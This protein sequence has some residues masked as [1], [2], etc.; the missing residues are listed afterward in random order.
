MYSLGPFG[1]VLD[2]LVDNPV[3]LYPI[4]SSL[5]YFL[6]AVISL[7]IAVRLYSEVLS[8]K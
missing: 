1:R 3:N 4:T 2:Y 5:H 6:A 8:V 7:F